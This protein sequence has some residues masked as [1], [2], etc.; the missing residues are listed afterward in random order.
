[1][2]LV[3][4]RTIYSHISNIRAISL[5]EI[6]ADRLLIIS[7]GGRAQICLTM[8]YK[9]ALQTQHLTNYML[10]STDEE[11]KKQEIDFDPETRFMCATLLS[12]R[13][14]VLGC[15]DGYIRFFHIDDDFNID[16]KMENDYG[17]CILN[18]HTMKIQ[19][20]EVIF[21]MATDGFLC[22]WERSALLNFM[23]PIRKIRHNAS[24]INAFDIIDCGDYF[25]VCTG[26]DDQAITMTK[27]K[28]VKR[29]S[30][31]DVDVHKTVSWPQYHIAQVSGVRLLDEKTLLT[32][33]VDQNVCQLEFGHTLKTPAMM[34]QYKSAVA[35]IKGI[36]TLY[37][38]RFLVYG[39]GFEVFNVKK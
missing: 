26:G 13:I 22:I 18:V 17:K 36:V 16:L 39:N 32:T 6:D 15:S 38:G 30:K 28:A 11:R 25:M 34:E 29:G 1:M 23:P 3:W 10:K 4:S 2:N 20:V 27:F 35:D 37:D 5:A 9:S 21:T 33:G 14:L 7:A 24:G 8:F 19:D 31:L 12:D